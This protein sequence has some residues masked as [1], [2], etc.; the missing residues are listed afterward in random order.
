MNALGQALHQTGDADLVD[1][2][3]QLPRAGRAEQLAHAGIRRD[4][5]LGAAIG[6][7]IA[8]AHHGQHAV[9]GPG[10]A[11]GDGSVDEVEAALLRLGMELARDL[12]R[13][14]GVVNEHRAL[15]H[16]VERAVGPERDLAQI[17]I[18]ADAAHDEVLARG[19]R[20]GRRRAEAAVPSDPLFRLG[21]GTVVTVSS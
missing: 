21:R 7:G 9:L 10:L 16:A 11:A 12:G 1:H 5:L 2:L 19:G 17:V 6:V 14:R 3:G 20:F 18:I 13:S 4:H 15:V 8:A